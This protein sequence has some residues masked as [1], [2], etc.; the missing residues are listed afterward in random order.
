MKPKELLHTLCIPLL[1]LMTGCE[2]PDNSAHEK[3]KSCRYVE[4]LSD[5]PGAHVYGSDGNYWGVTEEGRP[6]TRVFS[7]QLYWDRQ[8]AKWYWSQS[9][10]TAL[11][12][13]LKKRG[14]KPTIQ[15]VSM[16]T[17]SCYTLSLI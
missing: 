11:T 4:I 9:Y 2:T 3:H 1:V 14:Y 8:D 12:V 10:S 15:T 6:V 17:F 13:T 7:R 5:P 16:P